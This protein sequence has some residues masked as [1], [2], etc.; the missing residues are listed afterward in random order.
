MAFRIGADDFHFMRRMPDGRW[1][2]KC[3]STILRECTDDVFGDAWDSITGDTNY[4]SDIYF[5]AVKEV[6]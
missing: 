1:F 6:A 2:E 3:G 5:F 4:D